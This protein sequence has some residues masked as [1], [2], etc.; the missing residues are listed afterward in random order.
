MLRQPYR[1]YQP[2]VVDSFIF[3]L[4]NQAAYRVDSEITTEVTN[5]LF[6]KPGENFGLDLAAINVVR[7]REMGIPG[8]NELREFCGMSRIRK[9]EELFGLIDN[10]TI[11]RYLSLY[12]DVDD[13]DLWSAGIAEFP[14]VG[15]MVGPT[16]S[17]LIAEQFAQIRNGDRFWYENEGWP[18]QFTLK[19]LTELRKVKLARFLC[20][21]SDDMDT[22]QLYPMLTAHPT[23]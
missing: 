3:G 5:H 13:I 11:H 21:N 1:L 18:S 17:C 19:Q 20:D 8:Y 2:G 23:T 16:F 7:S 9:F 14:M 10:T 4:M 15:A 22:V 12:N 6:E